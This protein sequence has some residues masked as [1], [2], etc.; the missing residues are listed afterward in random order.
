ML[1]FV[2]DNLHLG[3]MTIVMLY[4]SLEGIHLITKKRNV[5]GAALV[6]LAI[7]IKLLPLVLLPWLFYRREAYAGTMVIAFYAAFMFLPSLFIG[8]EYNLFLLREWAVLVNP[9]KPQHLIDVSEKSFHGLSTM[10]P[11]LLMG[12]VRENEQLPIRRNIVN[13][14]AAQVSVVLMTVRFML[15]GFVLYFLR[16]LP[17]KKAPSRLHLF[18]EV[19]YLLLLIPLI[20]PHQQSYV[21]FLMSPAMVYVCYFLL[22]MRLYD[23]PHFGKNRFKRVVSMMSVVFLIC[24]APIIL[25]HFREYYEHFKIL[26]YS[27]L[28]TIIP[29]ALCKPDYLEKR[30]PQES[31]AI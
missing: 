24:N 10:L 31:L 21:F 14:S 23:Y 22:M 25:G 9:V 16:T 3:Q 18:W 28:L 26:T 19:S 27:G 20:F 6:A 4:L 5:G 12:D 29:L 13:L 7:N 15:I 1:R 8:L 17:F 30:L 2:R 11:T